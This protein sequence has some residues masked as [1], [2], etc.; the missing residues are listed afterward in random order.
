[1]DDFE[2]RAVALNMYKK[3]AG[4]APSQTASTN[5][6]RS[7][8]ISKGAFADPERYAKSVETMKQT[9]NDIAANPNIVNEIN[10]T[11][12][13]DAYVEPKWSE[14]PLYRLRNLF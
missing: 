10:R 2:V 6:D 3:L 12:N 11:I 8:T 1:M 14:N 5:L 9:T 13:P 7:Y 4:V